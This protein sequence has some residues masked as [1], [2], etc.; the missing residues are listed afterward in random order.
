MKTETI[1]LFFLLL[2]YSV[3]LSA[4]DAAHP[5]QQYDESQI[6]SHQFD[7]DNWAETIDGI[8]YSQSYRKDEDYDEDF[9][10][11]PGGEKKKKKSEEN[12]GGSSP[13]WNMFVKILF[14]S[15][16][17]A[18]LLFVV[19]SIIKG[20]IFRPRSKDFSSEKT[21]FSLETVEDNIHES[22]LDRFIKEALAEENYALAIRL[23]YLAIIKE[24][25]INRIIK[26]KRDKTNR[27]YLRELKGYDLSRD[28]RDATRIFERI[29]YGNGKL[30]QSDFQQIQPRFQQLINNA[31][32]LQKQS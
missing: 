7:Y 30:L 29:W 31:R 1:Y 21:K 6:E 13:F 25:S 16:G 27:D 10:D 32:N 26:W 24:L 28:F 14:I 5:R 3:G 12:L 11:T 8:D 17:V 22:D 18:L 2:L 20:N 9:G 15:L 4:Q 19:I 23:Y